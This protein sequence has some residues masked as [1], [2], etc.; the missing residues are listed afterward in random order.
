MG[1]KPFTDVRRFIGLP[2]AQRVLLVRVAAVVAV[3]RLALWVMPFASLWRLLQRPAST[4]ML[5]RSFHQTQTTELAWAVRAASRW[6][7]AA[8]CLTQSLALQFLLTH[9]GHR[10]MLRIGVARTFDHLLTAHAWVDCGGE[11][12]LDQP[13]DVHTYSVLASLEMS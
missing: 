6:I 3:V 10:C 2:H 7:P 4:R 12:L 9:T 13:A 1:V 8:T 5:R 11:V